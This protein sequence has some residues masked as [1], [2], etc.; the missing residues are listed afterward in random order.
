MDR[1]RQPV[2]GRERNAVLLDEPAA[3]LIGG[4]LASGCRL[5][6]GHV[7]IVQLDALQAS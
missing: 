6:D 3:G 5:K 2:C 1:L 4:Q 7:S